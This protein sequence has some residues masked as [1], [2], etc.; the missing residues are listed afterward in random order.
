MCESFTPPS[1]QLNCARC[2]AICNPTDR[3]EHGWPNNGRIEMETDCCGGDL[4]PWWYNQHPAI[5][6]P[7]G[8]V[9]PYDGKYKGGLCRG[10]QASPQ[11][12]VFEWGKGED[13]TSGGRYRMCRDCHR[14]LWRVL[15]AFFERRSQPQPAC[16]FE[17]RERALEVERA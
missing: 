12:V 2:G 11:H 15:G 9:P 8:F 17:A 14:D 16:D 4:L 6:E 3:W 1:E 10:G 7:P 5:P 13:C